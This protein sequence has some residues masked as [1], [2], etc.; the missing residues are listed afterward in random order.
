MMKRIRE[1]GM[2]RSQVMQT[3]SYLTD[4]IGPRLD[5]FPFAKTR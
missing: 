3:V 1:E 2:N 5:G 4:V